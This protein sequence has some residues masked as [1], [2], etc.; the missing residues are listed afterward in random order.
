ME[1]GKATA[2]DMANI[3]ILEDGYKKISAKRKP[4]IEERSNES[5]AKT[6][7]EAA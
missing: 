6:N 5:D 7:T 4:P 3:G 2:E 1:E